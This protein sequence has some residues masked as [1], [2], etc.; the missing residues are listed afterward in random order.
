VESCN[1]KG[2]L[3]TLLIGVEESE[4]ENGRSERDCGKAGSEQLL[5]PP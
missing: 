3:E 2:A 4:K 5:G 1:E